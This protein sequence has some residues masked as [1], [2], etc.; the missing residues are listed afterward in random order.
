MQGSTWQEACG[1]GS[2]CEDTPAASAGW[3]YSMA[4]LPQHVILS[5][6]RVPWPCPA[7]GA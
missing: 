7:A 3:T 6:T 2:L 1:L 4:R 5:G